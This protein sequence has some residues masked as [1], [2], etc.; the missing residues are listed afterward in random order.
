VK[1]GVS[2]TREL[3]RERVDLFDVWGRG[4]QVRCPC[5]KCGR[6]APGQ[7]GLARDVVRKRIED[8]KAERTKLQREPSSGIGLIFNEWKGR[9]K[10][11]L[12][13]QLL[14]WFCRQPNQQSNCDHLDTAFSEH[15]TLRD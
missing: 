8:S 11:P 12:E 5:H 7:V 6:N 14:A 3:G 2:R 1:K 9:L 4:Q 15:A 10:E 13:F